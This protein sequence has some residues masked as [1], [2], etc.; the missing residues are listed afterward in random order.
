[1]IIATWYGD[2]LHFK[3]VG[4]CLPDDDKSSVT[5]SAEKWKAGVLRK[6]VVSGTQRHGRQG[7]EEA[8]N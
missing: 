4:R 8:E 3:G 5:A 6:Y 7:V 1:M 2:E